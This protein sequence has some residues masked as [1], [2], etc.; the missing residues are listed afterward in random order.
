MLVGDPDL[1]TSSAFAR[2]PAVSWGKGHDAKVLGQA[3]VPHN[4]ARIRFKPPVSFRGQRTRSRGN[5][6]PSRLKIAP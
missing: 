5:C 1:R 6:Q 4:E 3:K 2:I